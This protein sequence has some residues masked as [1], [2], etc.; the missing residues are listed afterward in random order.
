MI[1][2]FDGLVS[3]LVKFRLRTKVNI[4]PVKAGWDHR[5]DGKYKKWIFL[6]NIFP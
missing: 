6:L 3:K 5:S 4:H 2:F 1:G